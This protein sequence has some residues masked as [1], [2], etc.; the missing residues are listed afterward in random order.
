MGGRVY[1]VHGL[2]VESIMVGKTWKQEWI[3]SGYSGGSM[4]LFA[5]FS[6]DQEPETGD[7]AGLDFK[8][9]KPVPLQ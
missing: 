1:L 3:A 7:E 2:R 9:L 5:C 8:T 4:R 6:M